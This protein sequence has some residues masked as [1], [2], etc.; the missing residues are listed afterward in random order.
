M[1]GKVERNVFGLRLR[2]RV[3]QIFPFEFVELK[4]GQ[5]EPPTSDRDTNMLT[6]YTDQGNV[7]KNGFSPESFIST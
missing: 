3:F 4:M 7:T 2:L 6:W 5:E 1:K